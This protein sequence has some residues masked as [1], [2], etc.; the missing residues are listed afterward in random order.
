MKNIN[1]IIVHCS[2]S[3]PYTTYEDIDRW[4][5]SRGWSSCGYHFVIEHKGQVRVGRPITQQGAHCYGENHDS[6]GICLV[7][8][9]DG[10]GNLHRFSD[11]Q[12]ESLELVITGILY[13][14]GPL[15]IYGHRDFNPNKEC[16]CFDVKEVLNCDK[17]KRYGFL[18]EDAYDRANKS[19]RKVQK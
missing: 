15:D 6:I 17:K 19:L 16:P 12:L 4:H 7:G 3:G 1:K 11:K 5:C 13:S 2:A 10:K 9:K 8:G 14:L 18:R